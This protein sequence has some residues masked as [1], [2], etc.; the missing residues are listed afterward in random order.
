MSFQPPPPPPPKC[1]T[2]YG[3]HD[4]QTCTNRCL[5]C[6]LHHG[7]LPCPI[8]P[9]RYNM[10][11]AVEKR[12]EATRDIRQR[13]DA[14]LGR[15]NDLR[16]ELARVK[17]MND[18]VSAS[19]SPDEAEPE[20]E[21]PFRQGGWIA[22]PA[23]NAPAAPAAPAGR[24]PEASLYALSLFTEHFP[25]GPQWSAIVGGWAQMTKP[26]QKRFR[27]LADKEARGEVPM[28]ADSRLRKLLD[29]FEC[30]PEGLDKTIPQ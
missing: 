25:D 7:G 29:Q 1:P 21:G 6:Q 24:N 3:Q 19:C 22:Q 15:C 30:W 17:T 10:R 13:A 26:Q 16:V 14:T 12:A 18:F 11:Q 20:F 2:C 28:P 27:Q 4:W 9:Y 5:G 23:N 8:A